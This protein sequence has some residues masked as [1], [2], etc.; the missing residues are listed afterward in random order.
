MD[1]DLHLW[2]YVMAVVALHSRFMVGLLSPA[3]FATLRATLLF[4]TIALKY[5]CPAI[6]APQSRT[7]VLGAWFCIAGTFVGIS[8]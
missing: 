7:E 1:G 3:Y 4:Y 8:A 6:A 2:K 5:I